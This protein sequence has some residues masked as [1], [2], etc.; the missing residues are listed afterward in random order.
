[1]ARFKGLT[2]NQWRLIEGFFHEPLKRKKGKPHTP[3]RYVVNTILWILITGARWCDVPKGKQWASRSASH[4]WLGLWKES[5]LLEHLLLGLHDM[6]HIAKKID[7]ERLSVDGFFSA[8]KGGGEEITYGY[9][10]KGSTTHLLIDA[11]GNPLYTTS[12][13]AAG[14]ERKEVVPL[15]KKNQ[16]M[17]R[18][19]RKKRDNSNSRSR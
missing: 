7:L 2:D 11:H 17:A 14:D 4:R 13:S 8:G 6:A 19:S 16:K 15:I 3:W 5:G 18:A 12:T 9:K 1:M 10:G